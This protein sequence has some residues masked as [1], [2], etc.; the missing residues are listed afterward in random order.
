MDRVNLYKDWNRERQDWL[1]LLFQ[2]RSSVVP[3]ILSR[4]LFCVLFGVFITALHKLN[5]KV[6][7]PILSTVIPSLVLSLLLVFRTNTAYERYWEGRKLW[8][9]MVNT[10]RNLSR[11]IWV[12]VQEN[13]T[14]DRREKIIILRL[15]VAFAIATKIHLRGEKLN[16]DL[17][18]LMPRQWFAKLKTMN[19]PPLEIAFWI[20]DYLQQQYEKKCLNVY[21]LTAS[22]KLLDNLV[23]YLGGC[24][25][26]KKTPIPLAYS[27]HLKQLLLLYCL[28][29]PFQIVEQLGWGT[30]LITGIISFA[31]F[32]I[33]AIGI[34]IENPFGKDPNDLPLDDICQTME[35]NIED[36]IS[37]AP[38][39]RHWRTM[40]E[41]WEI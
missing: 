29:L 20:G 3:A 25:R 34:E 26:I 37:L 8:G 31:V 21:Q 12:T 11:S 33:E 10:V 32:G 27:I 38:S 1:K 35:I 36:L 39:V 41:T 13:Q 6:S 24:E 30:G 2:I 40:S 4:V 23:D 7:L 28:T 18:R 19:H 22:L 15:L 14:K 5:F 9:G 16:K 17:E